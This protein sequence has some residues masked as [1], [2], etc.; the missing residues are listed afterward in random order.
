MLQEGS[1]CLNVA[2]KSTTVDWPDVVTCGEAEGKMP[3][4]T[5]VT[6][7]GQGNTKSGVTSTGKG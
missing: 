7:G 4:V 6:S 5:L 3:A 2:G 1:S